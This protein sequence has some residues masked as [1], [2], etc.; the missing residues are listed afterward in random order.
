[1]R[2]GPI[3]QRIAPFMTFPCRKIIICGINLPFGRLS[4]SVRQVAHVLLT[5]PPLV[6][7]RRCSLARL[8]CVKHAASVHPEPGSNS[9]IKCSIH[10]QNQLLANLFP[11]L[12]VVWFVYNFLYSFWISHS[13]PLKR[14]LL[15]EFSGFYILFNLLF[16][17]CF[18]CCPLQEQLVYLIILS[19]LCQ[20]LFYFSFFAV[21]RQLVYINIS[22]RSCQPFFKFLQNFCIGYRCVLEEVFAAVFSGELYHTKAG[23]KSQHL[24]TIFLE[25]I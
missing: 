16:S 5:R 9:Q 18:L 3:L 11:V 17:K 10:G 22:Y 13:K 12:L 14:S 1:M 24:F 19:C 20:Q 2:R 8:A 25:I 15:L 7:T 6:H 23:D 21:F 4:P